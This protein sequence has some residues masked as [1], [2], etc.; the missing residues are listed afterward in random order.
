[1]KKWSIAKRKMAWQVMGDR[2][3]GG[4]TA[5]IPDDFNFLSG[6]GPRGVGIDLSSKERIETLAETIIPETT[7]SKKSQL[8]MKLEDR[9]MYHHGGGRKST[10]TTSTRRGRSMRGSRGSQIL[11]PVRSLFVKGTFRPDAIQELIGQLKAAAAASNA[12][13][14]LEQIAENPKPPGKR[15]MESRGDKKEESSASEELSEEKTSDS[16]ASL[17]DMD[18]AQPAPPTDDSAKSALARRLSVAANSAQKSIQLQPKSI[19]QKQSQP[20]P[21]QAAAKNKI[22]S[23]RKPSNAKK[24]IVKANV[25][26]T[27]IKKLSRKSS[28]DGKSSDG[29]RDSLPSQSKCEEGGERRGGEMGG[30][31]RKR[32]SLW[33]ALAPTMRQAKSR[34]S[35]TPD[36]G[37]Q[38]DSQSFTSLVPDPKS[39][40]AGGSNTKLASAMSELLKSARM[41]QMLKRPKSTGELTSSGGGRPEHAL[42]SLLEEVGKEEEANQGLY[43]YNPKMKKVFQASNIVAQ[44]TGSRFIMPLTQNYELS[45]LP[46][47]GQSFTRRR[48]R[49]LMY[50]TLEPIVYSNV[51]IRKTPA[52]QNVGSKGKGLAV[53]LK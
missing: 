52:L 43:R 10:T 14:S 28:N 34:Q 35:T 17:V 11:D 12:A 42:I 2:N 44:L 47:D 27:K 13:S 37:F 19:P 36:S 8:C 41:V 30:G 31:T 29:K 53:G 6:P 23:K 51:Y 15:P 9:W 38:S 25:S 45:D 33:G 48:T 32:G 49:G 26:T 16:T 3:I 21:N 5:R 24:A 22:L 4:H 20:V 50:E 46:K 18:E 39:Q 7:I 40:G 1:M